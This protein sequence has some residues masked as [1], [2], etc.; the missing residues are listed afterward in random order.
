MVI[1]CELF[2]WTGLWE[3]LDHR[4][5]HLFKRQRVKQEAV[6]AKAGPEPA[7]LVRCC[8]ETETCS[9]FAERPVAEVR[10]D[11]SKQKC[12][13]FAAMPHAFYFPLVKLSM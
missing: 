1:R 2:F 7:P 6:K 13:L 9:V 12:C 8:L 11:V 3:N 4:W 5:K 10:G